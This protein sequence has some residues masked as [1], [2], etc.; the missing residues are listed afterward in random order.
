MP[1]APLRGTSYF[2]R[3]AN[4]S[5]HRSWL[6]FRFVSVVSFV[7]V[8]WFVNVH[9]RW[10]ASPVNSVVR[11]LKS[12]HSMN[13][14]REQSDEETVTFVVDTLDARIH[15]LAAKPIE[16]SPGP[17]KRLLRASAELD[18]YSREFY[19]LMISWYPDWRAR[20]MVLT[21]DDS[22]EAL[23]VEVPAPSNDEINL[24]LSTQD[25]Q[26]TV[27]FGKYYHTHFVTY[28]PSNDA[29]VFTRALQFVTDFLNEKMVLAVAMSG[30]QPGVSWTVQTGGEITYPDL[31]GTQLRHDR[32][33]VFSWQSTHDREIAV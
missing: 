11:R 19:E 28:P 33:G 23:F 27:G 25:G 21:G 5:L 12:T 24:W 32:I 31:H 7:H 20:A 9:S 17:Q 8:S 1:L 29:T 18:D 4:K 6:G 15:E 13:D 14:Q 22:D 30:A 16:L 3:V 2:E 26:I 10:A